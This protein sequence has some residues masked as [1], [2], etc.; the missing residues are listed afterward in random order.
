VEGLQGGLDL[1]RIYGQRL[2]DDPNETIPDELLEYPDLPELMATLQQAARTENTVRTYLDYIEKE[3]AKPVVDREKMRQE[4]RDI[5]RLEYPIDKILIDAKNKVGEYPGHYMQSGIYATPD[6][7]ET[8]YRHILNESDPEVLVRLLWIFRRA[9]LPRLDD[10]LFNWA[11]GSHEKLRSAAIAALSR[12]K[13]ER[14]H[15]L[16]RQ[17]AETGS[18]LGAD[19]HALDLF[20]NNYESGDATLITSSLAEI[21]PNLGE[22]HSLGYSLRKVVEKNNDPALAE[23]LLWVYENT[24]CGVCRFFAIKQLH[25]WGSLPQEVLFEC[26]YDAEDDIREF[27]E[28]LKTQN[29]C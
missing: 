2:L 23:A 26:K 3:E 17:K 4:R 16:A 28:H 5:G 18:L 9:M 7:L 25:E 20:S 15:Q 6:E 29:S 21:E 13:D 1:A 10:K 11:N 12:V 24:P 27:A 19:Q 8:V 22:A 14:V